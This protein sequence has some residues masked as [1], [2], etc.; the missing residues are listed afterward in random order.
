M[1]K[2]YFLLSLFLLSVSSLNGQQSVARQ[3]NEVLLDAIRVDV[4]R[5]TVHARNLFHVSG[6]MYDAWAAYDEVAEPF[7]LGKTVGDYSCNFQGID[8]PS[9]PAVKKAAQEEAISYAAY[10]LLKHRF[11]S[12]PCAGIAL[13]EFDSLMVKLGYD[14][15]FVSIDYSGGSAAALGNYIA[16][17]C[18]EF[19]LVDHSDEEA[20][21]NYADN[22]YNPV[23]PPLNPTLPGNPGIV[24]LNHWQSLAINGSTPAKFLSPQWGSVTPFS[25]TKEDLVIRDKNGYEY[26][27]YVDPGSP[28]HIDTTGTLKGLEDF[29]KWNFALNAV[30]SGH[31]DPTDSVFIDISPN[32][33][34]HLTSLPTTE[35]E[36][37]NFYNFIEGGVIDTGYAINPVT[38]QAYEPQIVP[39]GDFARVLAEFWADG[40]KSETPPGHWFTILNYVSD[41]PGFEKRYEGEGPILND[42]EWDVKA[43]LSM[44]GA[45]HDVAIAVWGIKSYYDYVRPISAI[46]GMAELGQSSDSTKMSYHPGGLPLI[47]GH[48]ALVE[49]GDELAG[50]QNENVGKIKLYAWRGPSYITDPAT[51]FAG[52][53]WI[54][55]DNWWPYQRPSFITPPFAGYVSGH[56]TFSRAAAEVMT[57][58]TGDPYFPGGMG[59]FDAPKNKYLV[60]EQGPSVD[61]ELQWATYRDASDQ[62]SLSRLW[63]GIHPPIDDIPGRKIG[64]KI[65]PQAFNKAKEYF[66]GSITTSNKNLTPNTDITVMQNFPNPATEYTE[67]EYSV[68]KASRVNISIYD[69]NGRL[70]ERLDEGVKNPGVYRK[71]WNRNPSMTEGMYIYML[72]T[73]QGFSLPR[74][75]IIAGN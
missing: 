51:S 37:R 46:R 28:P 64:Q 44:G 71:Y 21:Y 13:P 27:V 57:L 18:M 38:G 24:D 11:K 58:L 70:I 68:R 55:A 3:W 69:L 45:V 10:R 12:S 62:A 54:L 56:S 49:A 17:S 14:T 74:K 22:F 42:L 25:L 34:G 39:L 72:E 53:G 15:S 50:A 36:F 33:V 26:D 23:N 59:V 9:D 6:V 43:Y 66:L 31:L 20:N 73:D 41:Y 40:P 63:G 32:A 60:F 19:G 5:P 30:W 8:V 48:I 65:G 2:F 1:K 75:L 29:Y 52:V 7:L 35:E 61:M 4:G 67:F 16:L 47:D